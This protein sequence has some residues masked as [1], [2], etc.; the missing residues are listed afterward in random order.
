M[1]SISRFSSLT[2]L[3]LTFSSLTPLCAATCP[4]LASLRTATVASS[5]DARLASGLFYENS[6]I[7]LAQIGASCQRMNKSA[8]SA[9]GSIIEDYSVYYGTIPFP[10]PL[11]YNATSTR[12]LFSRYMALAPELPF[13][14]V[15]VD[16]R[17]SA[18]GTRYDALTE[19]LCW[20]VLGL[21][22]VEV[23]LS[24]RWAQPPSG[25]IADLEATARAQGVEW[26]GNLTSVNFTGCPS[27]TS[28]TE[29][30]KTPTL[31]DPTADLIL[32]GTRPGLPQL[33]MIFIQGAE[34]SPSAYAPFL[35]ALQAAVTDF[36]LYIAAPD[37]PLIHT[38]DPI[39]IGL[40]IE[41]A[42]LKLQTQSGLNLKTTRF[43]F[44]AH[45]LGGLMLQDFLAALPQN[46][47]VTPEALV[48]TGAYITR[49]NRPNINSTAPSF[50]IPTLS[51]VGE[52]DG[53]AR[54][55]RFAEAW[56][57]Q[58]SRETD[59]QRRAAFPVL[60]MK[61]M[62]HGQWCHFDGPVPS[63][64]ATYDLIPEV[65][66]AVAQTT[67]ALN[68][69]AFLSATLGGTAAP[70]SAA[71]LLAAQA[72]SSAFL[73][74]LVSALIYECSYNLVPPCYDAPPSSSCAVGCS[75]TEHAQNVMFNT[76]GVAPYAFHATVIDAMHPVA[77]T[78]PI[79]L[80][81]ITNQCPAP[82]DQCTLDAST[83]TENTYDPIYAAF[84]VALYPISAHEVKMKLTSRQNGLLHAGVAPA[85][86]PF[87]VTDGASLCAELN[88]DTFAWALAHAA[89]STLA[90]YTAHGLQLRFGADNIGFAGPQFTDGSLAWGL[91]NNS[92]S[93][94]TFV[95]VNSTSLPTPVPY[96]IKLAEGF[97]YCLALSPLR[98]MEWIYVDGL[99]EFVLT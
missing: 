42:I 63:E 11:V 18:D 27:I 90:R 48:L 81:N 20:Q 83:V 84:D 30:V 19:Y 45:S 92:V 12:G 29:G 74:P 3:F 96:F 46:F 15:V 52:L 13:P 66:E 21:D 38:P 50:N 94:D 53:L 65:T 35:R 88:A 93:N 82:N 37:A 99:R 47:S 57:W 60:V 23:R 91:V 77:D 68:I 95:W 87:N 17:L 97:H 98:A 69:A 89:P 59:L 24:T 49:S 39:T 73:A 28:S 34:V 32:N 58:Q 51:I 61:G 78:H 16:A 31:S 56:W 9:T 80:G 76:V 1:H 72:A 14:S 62:S 54:V 79:H 40:D 22:Y 26:T 75:F 25:L 2:V 64:V 55:S 41:R 44:G 33:A 4:D 71:T 36:D 10:L 67:G 86:A 8:T 70:V 7:D 43:V 85:D 5:F 6:Y